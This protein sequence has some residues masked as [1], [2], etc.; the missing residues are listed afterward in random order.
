[1]YIIR[2]KQ[3][4]EVVHVDMRP[5]SENL[6]AKDIFPD[7]DPSLMEFGKY[8][9]EEVPSDFDIDPKGNVLV[10]E[11]NN[12]SQDLRLFPLTEE[13]MDIVPDNSAKKSEVASFLKDVGV[14]I[15]DDMTKKEMLEV[16]DQMKEMK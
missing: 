7:F 14:V 15:S 4:E 2:S 8:D 1:M 10:L 12:S 13:V 9:G 16:I 5:V 6:K 3:T 11:D